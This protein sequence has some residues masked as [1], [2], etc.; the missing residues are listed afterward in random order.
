MRCTHC[1]GAIDDHVAFCP[2]CGTAVPPHTPPAGPEAA[3]AALTVVLPAQPAAPAG[4]PP[5]VPPAAPTGPGR[6]LWPVLVALA[7]LV[8]VGGVV[9]VVA[10][11]WRSDPAP[12]AA[13]AS[14]TPTPTT[15]SPR[16]SGGEPTNRAPIPLPPLDTGAPDV[17]DFPDGPDVPDDNGDAYA[18]ATDVVGTFLYAVQ[19]GRYD[20]AAMMCTADFLDNVGGIDG[21]MAGGDRLRQFEVSNVEAA[22]DSIAVY[23]DEVWDSGAWST[24]Y[25]VVTW[26]G[27]PLVGGA[28]VLST[29]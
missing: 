18:T 16:P 5:A 6:W 7:V 25:Y 13:S 9:L 4:A 19:E 24:V 26:E 1:N 17:P 22:G 21:L 11:P 23:V 29:S 12:A 15:A 2:H 10:A 14:A 8:V 28:E 3:S 27:P 20:D